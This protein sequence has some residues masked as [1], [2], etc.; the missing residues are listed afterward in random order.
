MLTIAW[1]Q[2]DSAEVIWP[3]VGGVGDGVQLAN[4]LSTPGPTVKSTTLAAAARTAAL[5]P[6]TATR[7]FG[8]LPR[9]W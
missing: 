4:S 6:P 9:G 8:D 5:A 7:N 1:R 2:V 3:L